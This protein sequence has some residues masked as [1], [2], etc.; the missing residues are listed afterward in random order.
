MASQQTA[1]SLHDL[2][3]QKAEHDQSQTVLEVKRPKSVQ[4]QRALPTPPPPAD[5]EDS[6]L[7]SSKTARFGAADPIV[8]PILDSAFGHSKSRPSSAPQMSFRQSNI[9]PSLQGD[10]TSQ[11]SNQSSHIT[12][13][14]AKRSSPQVK[15]NSQSRSPPITKTKSRDLSPSF[16][17]Y[18]IAPSKR[19]SQDRQVHIR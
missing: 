8:S 9:I 7:P 11:S 6:P 17:P 15:A 5:P 18:L 14:I 19:V 4:Q 10:L 12:A 16:R 1:T 2:G 13:P 3:S